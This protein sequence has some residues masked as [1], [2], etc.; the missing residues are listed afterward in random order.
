MHL[1]PALFWDTNPNNLDFQK[2]ARY[3][4]MRV[5]MYGKLNEWKQVLNFYGKDK[6]AEE[7]TQE[8]ELDIKTVHFLSLVL[9]V[10]LKNF[11]C[12]SEKR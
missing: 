5:V 1:N 7:M 10:P 3:I 11:R 9:D 2:H 12:Y 4:I 6:I 8:R